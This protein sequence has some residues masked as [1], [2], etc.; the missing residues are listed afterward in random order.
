[1]LHVLAGIAGIALLVIALADAFDTIVLARRAERIFRLTGW[2]YKVTWAA[3]AYFA[4]QIESGGRRERFLSVYGPLS[5]LAL[6]AFWGVS[7]VMAFGLLHWAAS[8]RVEQGGSGFGYDLFFSAGSLIT[9]SLGEPINR[10]SKVF[11]VIEAGLGYSLLGLVVG[12]L[13][14][15]YQSYADREQN[16]ALLDPRAGS[17]PS[18]SELIKRQGPRPHKLEQQLETWGHWA[19][20]L[21]ESQLAY[22]MLAYFRSQHP[23]QSW[24]SALVT[25]MDASALTLLCC[26]GDLQHQAELTFAMGRHALA[27]LATVFRLSPPQHRSD[28]LPDSDFQDLVRALSNSKTAIDP[29]RLSQTELAKLRE[30]YEPFAASLSERFLMA[31]PGWLPIAPERDN[32]RRSSWEQK[33]A[34]YAVS[35]PFRR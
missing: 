16:I 14:V 17:P 23:N 12:Y 29:G 15:L 18:A 22:P 6:L 9:M 10:A 1:M 13:P 27:D 11:M 34:P 4:R 26:D 3:Y 21:L 7:V 8:L 30:M 19:S 35:D 25:V 31:V 2:F 20:K 32:W 28:R 33:D 24:L 5:L